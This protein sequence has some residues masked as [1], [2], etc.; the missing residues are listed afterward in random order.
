MLLSW[1]LSLLGRMLPGGGLIGMILQAVGVGLLALAIILS[2]TR[3]KTG[4]GYGAD[5]GAKMWRGEAVSYGNP[6]GQS[7]GDR[8]RRMF[9]GS[10]R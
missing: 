9:G 4:V 7:L 8:I 2:L 6:Y 5:A 10:R 1:L 3:R